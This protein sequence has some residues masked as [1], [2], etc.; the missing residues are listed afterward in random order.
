MP[1]TP[2]TWRDL[3]DGEAA[4]LTSSQADDRHGSPGDTTEW[5]LLFKQDSGGAIVW[6]NESGFAAVWTA[7]SDHALQ[8]AW[9][10]LT[11]I[12]LLPPEKRPDRAGLGSR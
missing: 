4:G 12:Q 1:R 9:R 6:M 10:E 3:I 7:S 11:G 8:D 2:R 5:W